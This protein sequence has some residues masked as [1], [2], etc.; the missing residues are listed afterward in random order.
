MI[1]IAWGLV[2]PLSTCLVNL[3]LIG[4]PCSRYQEGHAKQHWKDTQ[5]CYSLDLETQRVWDYVGDSF[6]HRLNHSKSD[7]KHAKF[8]SK[9]K[10]SGDDCVNCSCNDDSDMGGAMF[11][12][13]AET[14]IILDSLDLIY[15]IIPY[16]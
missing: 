13:K 2:Q 7:A 1:Y 3:A 11:S 16:W 4:S 5:H 10:Y 8:K 12:S 15:S 14:V 6:V 9:C